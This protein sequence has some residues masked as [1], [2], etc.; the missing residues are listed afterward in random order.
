MFDL[1]QCQECK[2]N[3]ILIVCTLWEIQIE[4]KQEYNGQ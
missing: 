1:H 3:K 2:P 4:D